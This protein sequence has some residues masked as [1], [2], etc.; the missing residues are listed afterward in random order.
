M[1]KT[2]YLRNIIIN[3]YS[4]DNLCI[5]ICVEF[6]YAKVYNRNF[7]ISQFHSIRDE[8]RLNAAAR[9]SRAARSAPAAKIRRSAM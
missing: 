3:N 2:L 6:F 9:K 4:Y 5:K 8:I 1:Y 7:G